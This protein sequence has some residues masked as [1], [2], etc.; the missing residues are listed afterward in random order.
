MCVCGVIAGTGTCDGLPCAGEGEG[1]M[2]SGARMAHVL[3]D[4]MHVFIHRIWRS[5][6][7]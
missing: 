4:I 5:N 2:V 7:P 3:A 1:I 6:K